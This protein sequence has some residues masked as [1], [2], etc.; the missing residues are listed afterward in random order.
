[1]VIIEQERNG[2][3]VGNQE[4]SSGARRRKGERKDDYFERTGTTVSKKEEESHTAVKPDSH[5][6]M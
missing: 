4:V 6:G 2:S 5:Q 3:G 1:M